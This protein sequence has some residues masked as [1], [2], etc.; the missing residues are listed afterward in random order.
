V[1]IVGWILLIGGLLLC[2]SV[3][4]A[5]LGFLLMAIG[6]IAL[7]VAEKKRKR[8]QNTAVGGE[9]VGMLP[10]PTPVIHPAQAVA[11]P[12][13][14]PAPAGWAPRYASLGTSSYDKEAWRRLVESDPELQQLA[15][16]LAR[17]GQQYVD[18]FAS[19]YLAAP[20]KNR[21]ATIVDEII[22]KA[23]TIDQT[24]K[25]G[26]PEHDRQ[27][28]DRT[29]GAKNLR[30]EPTR[31]RLPEPERTDATP[32]VASKILTNEAVSPVVSAIVTNEA[33]PPGAAEPPRI[34]VSSVEVPSLQATS[35]PP[36]PDQE[37][38]HAPTTS[39]DDALIELIRKF[40]PDSNFL[41]EG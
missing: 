14:A 37:P 10:G 3:A 26:T 2:V 27:L 40:A 32:P 23:R 15:S 20:E 5:A 28:I 39:A 33:V 4:W 41:R 13:I 17:Y 7:Q 24:P 1:R 21:I 6:L 11:G 31:N 29:P 19:S 22:A 16:V 34:D 35:E 36:K 18:Q 30:N 25:A 8:A 9:A 38:M 12:Q